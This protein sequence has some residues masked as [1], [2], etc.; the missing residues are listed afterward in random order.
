M[1]YYTSVTRSPH[2]I[3][4]IKETN[5]YLRPPKWLIAVSHYQEL[6][7]CKVNEVYNVL[8]FNQSKNVLLKGLQCHWTHWAVY[9]S[10]VKHSSE[11][12]RD[13]N[14]DLEIFSTNLVSQVL[15]NQMSI[16]EVLACLPWLDSLAQRSLQRRVIFRLNRGLRSRCIARLKHRWK[17]Y[18]RSTSRL[19]S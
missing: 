9:V 15:I 19:P 16:A 18:F 6:L 13:F 8:H 12:L 2:D 14:H 10:L 11:Q 1:G 7:L 17:S 4:V 5:Q 3:N